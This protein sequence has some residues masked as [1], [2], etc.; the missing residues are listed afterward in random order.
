MGSQ[1]EVKDLYKSFEG[2][3]VLQGVNLTAPEGQITVIL[4]RSGAGKSVLLKHM[5]G[6]LKPD[7]GQVIVGGRDITRMGDKEITELRKRFG[8]LFQE[9]ALFDSLTVAENVAFPLREH[10]KLPEKEIQEI[11]GEKLSQVGL[12]ED[13]DKMPSELSGGMRR[14][15][16]LAR[17][18]ALDP[19]IVLFDEP[20][21]GLDPVVA[22]TIEDLILE[23]QRRLGKTFVVITHDLKTAL[24]IG[25]RLALLE[26]GRIAV[27]G[28]PEEVLLSGHP[29]LEA[30][31]LRERSLPKEVKG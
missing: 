31:L 6:L 25:G 15:A 30:F 10:T 26:Q 22:S 3:Q 20:T 8:M 21:T 19:D 27:E 4:G 5:I 18:L 28:P 7:R 23:T 29:L 13:K 14:R 16:A 2:R 1:I 17:A 9:G 24:R 11:V 12:A